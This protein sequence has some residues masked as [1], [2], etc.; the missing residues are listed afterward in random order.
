[1]TWDRDRI[2]G[3]IR[4]GEEEV[5][6]ITVDGGGSSNA[7]KRAFA[8]EGSILSAASISTALPPLP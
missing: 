1:M 4:W 8:V 2:V 7:F 3:R 6:I 5:R